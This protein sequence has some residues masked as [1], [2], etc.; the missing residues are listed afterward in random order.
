MPTS[1]LTAVPH[2]V[3]SMEMAKAPIKTQFNIR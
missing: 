1:L 2:V 3:K